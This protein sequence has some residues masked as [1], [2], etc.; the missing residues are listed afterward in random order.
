LP[1]ESGAARLQ[2]VGLF[3]LI[4]MLEGDEAPITERRLAEI[5]GQ[6]Q[7]AVTGSSSSCSK[8]T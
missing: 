7:T 1:D 8:S 6:A 3:T 4:L 2:Q 5:T